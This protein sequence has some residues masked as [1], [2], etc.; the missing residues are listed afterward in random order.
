MII[1]EAII[2]AG[3]KGTR[4]RSVVSDIPKPMAKIQGKP[5]LEILIETFHRKGI[6]HFILSVGYL[7]NIIIDHFNGRYPGIKIS[8]SI[9]EEPLGTGGAIR[10]AMTK[11]ETDYALILNGDS[12]FDVD[13]NAIDTVTESLKLPVIFGRVVDDVSRYGQFLY[14]D[15]CAYKYVEKEGEGRGCVNGGI[16]IFHKHL[17]D[18]FEL[19]QKFSIE[20]DFFSKISEDQSVK[21]IISDRYFIDI[22]IPES[23]GYAQEELGPYIIKKA[24]FLDRD[25][26]VNVDHGY[27]CSQERCDFVN[28]IVDLLKRAREKEYLIIIVTNQAGIGRGYYSEKDFHRFMAWMNTA[29][30]NSIDAY[31]FCPYHAEQGVGRYKRDSYDRKPNPGMFLKAIK[32]HNLDPSLSIM[33]GDKKS[34][35][36]AASKANISRLFL[37]SNKQPTG[38][39]DFTRISSLLE[40]EDY[41]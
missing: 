23:Y 29:L 25:G 39:C 19:Y 32:E 37:Y 8:F 27:V 6:N 16:Y 12:L 18:D 17:L 38:S 35:L 11:L 20:N 28:G 10:L 30:S 7:S 36:L 34:D 31:Y 14:D 40:L 1:R 24:L 4:L 22:G 2:L 5:F 13:L 26:V 15:R 3:G 33:V 41:L 9:E 21:L